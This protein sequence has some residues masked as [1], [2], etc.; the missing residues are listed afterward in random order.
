M[1]DLSIQVDSTHPVSIIRV[2]GEIDV[3]TC[4]K[5]NQVLAQHIAS[6][7]QDLVLDL[8]AIQYID[9]TGLGVIAHSARS[10]SERKGTIRVICTQNQVLKVFELS[11]LHKKNVVLYKQE[12]DAL[13]DSQ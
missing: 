7:S 12:A 6:S 9:S 3:H 8:D 13:K 2:Q 1:S 11:G 5:L 10:L 4:P